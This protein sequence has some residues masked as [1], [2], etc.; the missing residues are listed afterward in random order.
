MYQSLLTNYHSQVNFSYLSHDVEALGCEYVKARRQAPI[1]PD[2]K[3]GRAAAV[4]R[5]YHRTRSIID[6]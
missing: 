4:W 6:I 2:A 1:L 3:S 5:S